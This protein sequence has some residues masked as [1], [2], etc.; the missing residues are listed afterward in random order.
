MKKIVVSLLAAS[1]IFSCCACGGESGAS[2]VAAPSDTSKTV[3]SVAETVSAT[4]TTPEETAT[5]VSPEET[6]DRSQ[7][8]IKE[9]NT[10]PTIEETIL[11]DES[12][13]KITATGIEYGNYKAELGLKIENSTGTELDVGG[14]GSMTV[15]NFT[16]PAAIWYT[17]PANE[18]FEDKVN[19]DLDELK[20]RGIYEIANIGMQLTVQT[21][22]TDHNFNDLINTNISIPTS[23]YDSYVPDDTCYQKSISNAQTADQYGYE[24]LNWNADTIF[25]Q[26]GIQFTSVALLKN[27]D[28]ERYMLIEVV[29]ANDTPVT[30]SLGNMIVSGKNVEDG[31]VNGVDIFGQS[32]GIITVQLDSKIEQYLEDDSSVED[33]YFDDFSK[34]DLDVTIYT[35]W[36][37][38]NAVIEDE[39]LAISF[40]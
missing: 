27:S 35:G 39:P 36:T 19:I 7:F 9:F 3:G 8:K 4:E 31:Y 25:D 28:D 1:L 24:L 33:T 16:I 2:S 37:G 11:V 17:V 6:V 21:I 5:E 23:I 18:V 32:R 15:N 40:S 13:V 22:D 20:L 26:Y 34:I 30:V 10:S 29:N 12:G 38:H 14:S